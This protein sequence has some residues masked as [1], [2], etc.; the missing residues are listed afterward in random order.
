[1]LQRGPE[2]LW[3]SDDKGRCCER[4]KLE[5]EMR[6]SHNSFVHVAKFHFENFL[7]YFGCFLD[8]IGTVG[9]NG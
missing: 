8:D 7:V 4:E 9:L 2:T 3:Y 1:M 5:Q 6:K